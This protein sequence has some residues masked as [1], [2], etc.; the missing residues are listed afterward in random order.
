MSMSLGG[1]KSLAMNR[2]VEKMVKMS[3]T[4]YIVAKIIHQNYIF[5][6]NSFIRNNSYNKI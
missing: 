6:F 1:G 3:D 5:F 2:V 4:F